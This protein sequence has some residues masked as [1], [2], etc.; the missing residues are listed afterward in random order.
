MED[1][2]KDELSFSKLPLLQ[3]EKLQGVGCKLED[4]E[5][6]F[7][8]APTGTSSFF[9]TCFNGLNALSGSTHIIHIYVSFSF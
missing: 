6:N 3:Y 8:H 1:N 4:L 5:S 2:L 7:V 9:K